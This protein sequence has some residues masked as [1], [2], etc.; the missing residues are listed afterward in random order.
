M[1]EDLQDQSILITSGPTRAN[2]DAVRFITNRSSGRLGST[3][4][5]EALSRGANVTM[6]TGAG[7]RKPQKS[8][9]TADAWNRLSIVPIETVSDLIGTLE[10]ELTQ[11]PYCTAIIHAMAVL[12]YVP[13]RVQDTKVRSGKE[14]WTLRLKRTPK[15]ID[16]I[17]EWSP[18]SYL[19]G[20]KLEVNKDDAEMCRIACKLMEKTG[21]DL[22]VANDLTNIRDERHPAL[23]IGDQGNIVAQP[24]TKSDIASELCDVLERV[25]GQ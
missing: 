12:D 7:S 23:L 10:Q 25:L 9:M 8:S 17:K 22:V 5:A 18:E 13:E 24:Q 14:E 20:F 4:G 3:I 21:S 16:R 19:V 2:I 1:P 15:V 11:P 6:V